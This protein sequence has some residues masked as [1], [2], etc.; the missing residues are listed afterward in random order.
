MRTPIAVVIWLI[1][2]S[3]SIVGAVAIG[4]WLYEFDP[5]LA[6][7][8]GWLIIGFILAK[9]ASELIDP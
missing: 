8:A 1:G 2:M 6:K 9:A 7:A 3:M 4:R 5:E